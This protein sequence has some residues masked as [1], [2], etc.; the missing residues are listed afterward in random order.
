MPHYCETVPEV[1]ASEV[2]RP[3][4]AASGRRLEGFRTRI[5]TLV[6]LTQAD[7]RAR[8]GRG[9][10]R[11]VKWLLDPFALL[12][13]YLILVTFVLDRPGAY[14][15]LSLACAIVPFQLV[16][17]TVTN[18]TGAIHARESIILNM[19]FDRTLIPLATVLTETCAFVASL[20]MIAL[21]MAAY[22]VAPTG[23]LVWFPVLVLMTVALAAGVAYPAAL[24]GL[25]FREL[26]VL[27]ISLTRAMFFLAPGLV[28]LTQASSTARDLL[29]LNPL[30]GLFESYRDVFV[31]GHSPAAWDVLYPLA[32]SL[33]LGGLSLALYR[34]EQAQF[35]KVVE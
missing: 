25:W 27:G 33:V 28:P 19:A 15:G 14:P 16:M 17:G 31:V 21:T 18:G 12:G 26:R 22:G 24:F 34:S 8:Y 11:I 23:A 35:A 1:L 4:V 10:F 30:T 13:I 2:N 5:D 20:S 6:S 29:R 3:H 9:G 32:F 7:L